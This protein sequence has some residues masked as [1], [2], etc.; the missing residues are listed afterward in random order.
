MTHRHQHTP[1]ISSGT[2][3]PSLCVGRVRGEG[4]RQRGFGPAAGIDGGGANQPTHQKRV[5]LGSGLGC[6]G[7]FFFIGGGVV[8]LLCP[9]P[10]VPNGQYLAV[11]T[12]PPCWTGCRRLL[13]VTD[14]VA[15]VGSLGPASP[16]LLLF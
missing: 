14:F 12:G 11:A 13:Q 4:S 2:I 9:T 7:L 1:R 10:T 15:A 5:Q 6:H 3:G 8:T 16:P